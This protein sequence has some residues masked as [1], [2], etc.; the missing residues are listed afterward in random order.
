MLFREVLNQPASVTD[1]ILI[2]WVSFFAIATVVSILAVVIKAKVFV[3]QLRE[4][5]DALEVTDNAE[6][7]TTKKLKEHHKKVSNNEDI[8]VTEIL[9]LTA[10]EDFASD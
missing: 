10:H 2:P 3:K 9:C 7:A 8:L 6:T 5:R 4:R 1:G